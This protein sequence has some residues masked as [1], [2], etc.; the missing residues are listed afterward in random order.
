DFVAGVGPAG[1]SAAVDGLDVGAGRRGVVDGDGEA[2]FGRR[3]GVGI[4]HRQR[5]GGGAGGETRTGGQRAAAPRVRFAFDGEGAGAERRRGLPRGNRA[6]V[7]FHGRDSARRVAFVAGVG[8]DVVGAAFADRAG[9][10]AGGL[11]DH[12]FGDFRRDEVR[13]SGDF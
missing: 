8:V 5:V 7:R 4:G 6:D 1:D 3:V 11:A 9:D 13:R 12:R 10:A 2:A